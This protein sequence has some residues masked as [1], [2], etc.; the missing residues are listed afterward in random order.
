MLILRG[1]G[2]HFCAGADLNWM[3]ESG[4]ASYKKNVHEARIF[5]DMLA[6]FATFPVPTI[7]IAQGV[8]MGGALGFI[9]A[10]D[11]SIGADTSF[12]CLSEVKLGL[13]PAVIGPHVVDA[14]GLRQAKRY[15]LTAEKFDAATAKNLG[16]LHHM[17]KEDALEEQVGLVVKDLMS[18]DKVAQ[19]KAKEFLN[20]LV[21]A[22][23]E[24]DQEVFTAETIAQMRTLPSAQ[25]RLKDFFARKEK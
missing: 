13:I 5:A 16:L 18:G 14:I 1:A 10:A 24:G 3:R 20:D 17:V 19:R 15:M 23:F 2:A 21:C 6:A 25:A 7:V 8:S 9:A 12:F 22:D 11:I 4:A